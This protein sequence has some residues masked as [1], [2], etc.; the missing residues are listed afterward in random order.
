MDP[1]IRGRG[2]TIN[3]HFS[4][5]KSQEH[6]SNLIRVNFIISLSKVVV[7][8]G[9]HLSSNENRI[10]YE[11]ICGATDTFLCRFLLFPEEPAG[12]FSK[13]I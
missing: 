9:F 12:I 1:A 11:D 6:C 2:L 13:K 7:R 8:D 4:H 10:K 3:M 5:W